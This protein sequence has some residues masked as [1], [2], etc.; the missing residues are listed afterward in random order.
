MIGPRGTTVADGHE[1]DLTHETS[2][3]RAALRCPA[4]EAGSRL[5]LLRQARCNPGG[6]YM[7]ALPD[8]GDPPC[9]LHDVCCG[10]LQQRCSFPGRV[11]HGLQPGSLTEPS[12]QRESSRSVSPGS[13]FS[14]VHCALPALFSINV[15]PP[16]SSSVLPPVL[17][18]LLSAPS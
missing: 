13:S 3:P 12:K 2:P 16:H 18:L 14:S 5:R 8:R 6:S 1:M 7:N 10:R 15:A 17:D 9:L 4:S 11:Y